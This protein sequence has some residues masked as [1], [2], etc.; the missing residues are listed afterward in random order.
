[1]ISPIVQETRNQGYYDK[2]AREINRGMLYYN[3]RTG[4][5]VF[6]NRYC[7]AV[8]DGYVP[9]GTRIIDGKLDLGLFDWQPR[10]IMSKEKTIPSSTRAMLMFA[11]PSPESAAQTNFLKKVV[12]FAYAQLPQ[13]NNPKIFKLKELPDF[14]SNISNIIK[15]L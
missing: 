10:L 6:S 5:T 4:K 1:M 7:T 2:L 14:N 13:Q 15:K 3:N 9:H 12:N 11:H 8:I